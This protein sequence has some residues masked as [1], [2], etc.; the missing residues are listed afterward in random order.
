MPDELPG[1][2]TPI[3][4]DEAEGL[5]PSHVRT[6]DELNTWEQ[7]NILEAAMWI[8]RMRKPAL[9]EPT[10]REVHRRMFDRT[11]RWAGFYRTSD[12][13]IGAYWADVPVRVRDFIED[14]RYWLEHQVFPVD[15]AALRLHHRLVKIHPFPNGNGRH[16][17]LWCDLLLRQNGRPPFR[18]RAEELDHAGDAR[19]RYIHALRRADD[20]D[21]AEL[22]ALFLATRTASQD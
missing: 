6:R 21:F 16:A 8:Q 3:D 1:G 20:E 9:H 5:I 12:T 10:I 17:R 11:W 15:E 4:P 22:F 19:D 2:A 13:T 7:A 18:W 14:G